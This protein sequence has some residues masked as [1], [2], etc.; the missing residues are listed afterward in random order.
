MGDCDSSDF[1]VITVEESKATPHPSSTSSL[2]AQVSVQESRQGGS[3]PDRSKR[4]CFVG[5]TSAGYAATECGEEPPESQQ[6]EQAESSRSSF[7]ARCC[8][9]GFRLSRISR[10]SVA[11][12]VNTHQEGHNFGFV[13]V[14]LLLLVRAQ[15]AFISVPGTLNNT[16][17]KFPTRTS[18]WFYKPSPSRCKAL[19]PGWTPSKHHAEL[20][21]GSRPPTHCRQSPRRLSTSS[22]HPARLPPPSKATHLARALLPW[23]L[24]SPR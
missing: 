1:D 16:T 2:R 18:A 8:F 21:D 9:T 15:K 3:G 24:Q 11:M 6:I 13:L 7:N 22:N 12:S 19:A 5:Q 20:P 17:N 10:R 23:L 14:G 4:V